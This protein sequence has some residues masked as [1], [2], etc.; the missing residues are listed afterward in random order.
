MRTIKEALD[1]AV[2]LGRE[3]ARERKLEEM[4]EAGQDECNICGEAVPVY[5]DDTVQHVFDR[6][7]KHC[8]ERDDHYRDPDHGWM[9]L[10]E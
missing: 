2:N 4:K 3:R 8:E 1:L 9:L 10:E 6:I 7:I 5:E